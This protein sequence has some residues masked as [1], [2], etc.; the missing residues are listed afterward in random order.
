MSA[1]PLNLALRFLLEIA[2]LVA[3]AY[4]GWATHERP[5]HV[6]WAIGLPLLAAVLWGTFRVPGDPGDA[7]VAVPGLLRLLLEVLF[8]AGAV[9]LLALAER[10]SLGLAFGVVVV[11]HYLVSYDRVLWLVGQR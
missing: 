6:V 11:V 10:R 1:N 7:P 4:W 8:F 2:G 5:W 3:M 9:A